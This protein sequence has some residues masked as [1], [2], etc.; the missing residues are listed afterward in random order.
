[1][2]MRKIKG[3]AQVVVSGVVLLLAA[4]LVGLQWGNRAEF[5]LYGQNRHVNTL[6][7][8]G[9]CLGGGVVLW[10]MLRLL[11]RG[12]RTLRTPPDKAGQAGKA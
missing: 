12:I 7:L 2:G 5:S 8:M 9:L 11:G 6:V 3:W 10:W 4:V 1:M